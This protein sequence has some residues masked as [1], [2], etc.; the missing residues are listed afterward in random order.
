MTEGSVNT[1]LLVAGCVAV[2]SVAL[3]SAQSGQTARPQARPPAPAQTPAA[4]A[5][6]AT[7]AAAPDAA[8]QRALVDQYCVTCHNVRLKTA[9]LLLDQL[10]LSHLG[11]HAEIAEK[12]VRKL[13]AGVMPPTNM[14]RPDAATMESFIK[15]MES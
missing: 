10:D 6:K 14:K 12:V 13:R 5:P 15:W 7:A 8:T 11:D 9:N 2:M 4:A 1:R 3:V